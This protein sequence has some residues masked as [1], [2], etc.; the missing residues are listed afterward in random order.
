MKSRVAILIGTV[1]LAAFYIHRIA[2]TITIGDSAELAAISESY[3]IAH[4]PGYPLFSA[5]NKLGCV[6]SPFAT[7][8]YQTNALSAFWSAATIGLIAFILLEWTASWVITAP[9]AVLLACSPLWM[10]PA[11]VTE[12]FGLNSFF[13]AFLL[14]IALKNPSRQT[15]CLAAFIGGVGMG[16][17]HTLILLTPALLFA[18]WPVIR[19]HTWR[20]LL[21]MTGFALLGLSVYAFV[22]IRA[23]Q[24]PDMDWEEP[25]SVYRFWKLFT[26]A[27]YGAFQLAQ[28][29]VSQI[30]LSDVIGQTRYITGV[31]W[32]TWGP[33][34]L[35]MAAALWALRRSVFQRSAAIVWL[36]F[37]FTGPFFFF[38]AH[39][40]VTP[41]TRV[42]L[43]RFMVMALVPA[44]LLVGYGFSF[45]IPK[46]ERWHIPVPAQG[47]IA[48]ALVLAVCLYRAMPNE[49]GTFY[50]RDLGMDLLRNAPRDTLLFADRADEAEFSLA[51]LQRIEGRRPDVRFIDCNAGVSRSIYGPD[52]Y[53]IWGRP[54]LAARN[55]EE[56]R[57][58]RTWPGPVYYATHDPKMIPIPR[59]PEGL[60]FGVPKR[61]YHRRVLPW[62]QVLLFRHNADRAATWDRGLYA[63]YLGILAQDAF[64]SRDMQRGFE[65]YHGAE[66]YGRR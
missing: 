31:L 57:R 22:P 18:V 65:L 28:G 9:A 45:L 48:G 14:F 33:L 35:G 44:A 66:I 52:Y 46:L 49:R 63:D 1:V 25:A 51:Y 41:H 62:D 60:L 34:C 26:R 56:G 42:I 38:W 24:L 36:A 55:F 47:A 37:F 30:T 10:G 40:H 12:V 6:L 15:A 3:G 11:L 32:E 54:R 2:P 27:R 4:S 53:E 43:D 13:T 8:A 58:I 21:P 59:V 19:A 23:H 7:S 20:I 16:N 61:G 29:D 17:N 50:V 5:I 39:L 64:A